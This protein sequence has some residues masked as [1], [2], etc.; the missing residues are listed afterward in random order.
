MSMFSVNK[1]RIELLL[2]LLLSVALLL[3]AIDSAFAGDDY[4]VIKGGYF[5]PNSKDKGLSGFEKDFNLEAA[6]DFV[7]N[8]NFSLEAGI[9]RYTTSRS[10]SKVV[11]CTSSACIT[12][13]NVDYD[14]SVIPITLTAKAMKKLGK[15]KTKG[16]LGAGVG[17]YMTTV[18]V[19]AVGANSGTTYDSYSQ[20]KEAIGMQ[21]VGG[22][23]FP[24]NE[25]TSIG[26]ELKW[27]QAEPKYSGSK[28]DIGGTFLNLTL[29]FKL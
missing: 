24:I 1:I 17:Y 25:D 14:I 7:L 6:V 26:I 5:S 13:V 22:L 12:P 9:G 29:H 20:D 3:G 4:F 2:G 21:A 16:Y 18:K 10:D 23:D 15:G 28:V 27:I 11:Y 19:H 8:D